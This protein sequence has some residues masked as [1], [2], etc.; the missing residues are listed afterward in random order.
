MPKGKRKKPRFFIDEKGMPRVEANGDMKSAAMFLQTDI[1]A[2]SAM[3]RELLRLLN[4]AETG[5]IATEF[6]GNAYAVTMNH[7]QV[8]IEPLYE[9]QGQKIALQ[10]GEFKELVEK[11][12]DLIGQDE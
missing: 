5:P 6:V 2:D 3:A 8:V 11:W 1:Q 4:Q 7:D 9:G 10:H 12:L